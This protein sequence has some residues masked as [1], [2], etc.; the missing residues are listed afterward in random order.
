MNSFN[1]NSDWQKSTKDSR[2]AL[3]S[4]LAPSPASREA[5]D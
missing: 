3:S 2:A 4:G 5:R 1:P